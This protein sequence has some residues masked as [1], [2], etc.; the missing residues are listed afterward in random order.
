MVSI[1]RNSAWVWTV[2]PA[3]VTGEV[4]P[5][6]GH[7]LINSTQSRPARYCRIFET[8]AL[9]CKGLLGEIP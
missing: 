3:I 7:E 9:I 8:V 5:A 1:P 2:V 4:P 6:M